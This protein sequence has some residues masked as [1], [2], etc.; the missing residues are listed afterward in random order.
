MQFFHLTELRI[1]CVQWCSNEQLYVQWMKVSFFWKT[2]SNFVKIFF[3]E[4]HELLKC[5][6]WHSF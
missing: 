6:R 3:S 2:N 1:G 5:S 4:E